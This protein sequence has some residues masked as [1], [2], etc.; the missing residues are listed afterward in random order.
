[1]VDLFAQ[2][3]LN[4]QTT[5]ARGVMA[6]ECGQLLR[7][8]FGARRRAQKAAQ[9]AARAAALPASDDALDASPSQSPADSDRIH[10]SDTESEA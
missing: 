4:H 6:D 2:A 8:F 3:T 9:Q 7:D 10:A 5:L 1:V